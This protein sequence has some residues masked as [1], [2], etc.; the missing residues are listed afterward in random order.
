MGTT[1]AV[2]ER[3]R[4]DGVERSTG[5]A[6]PHPSPRQ[7]LTIGQDMPASPVPTGPAAAAAATPPTSEAGLLRLLREDH[8]ALRDVFTHYRQLAGRGAS[9][10]DRQRLAHRACTLVEMHASIGEELVYPAAVAQGEAD[11]L[12]RLEGVECETCRKIIRQVQDTPPDQPRF[13]ALVVALGQCVERRLAR[14]E[15][16]LFARVRRSPIDLGDL[17]RRIRR[18]H[19]AWMSL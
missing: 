15:A 5:R 3:L 13:D 19:E 10:E 18:R 11:D 12:I 2:R 4:H 17:C 1:V 7:R 14:E 16:E 9:A 8:E 6:E